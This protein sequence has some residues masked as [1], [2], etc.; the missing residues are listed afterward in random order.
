M[1]GPIRMLA[2]GL[3]KRC[4]WCGQGKL[5]RRWLSLKERCPRCHLRFER[6]EGAFLGAMALNYGVTGVA[7]IALLVIW[8]VVE[9]PDVELIPLMAASVAVTVVVPLLFFPFSKTIWVAVDLLLHRADT[10][11]PD[12]IALAFG[13]GDPG[14]HDG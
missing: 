2:R 10:R 11:D 13:V 5:F 7:F 3:A 8:L 14:A 12:S 4:P 1:P 6:E 9:L